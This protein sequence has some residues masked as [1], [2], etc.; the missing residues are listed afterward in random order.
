MFHLRGSFALLTLL[1]PS[2]HDVKG[3][4]FIKVLLLSL[5]FLRPFKGA[6]WIL[7]RIHQLQ[8][9][10]PNDEVVVIPLYIVVLL[11]PLIS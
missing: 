4:Y 2:Y 8:Q 6:E 1:D 10:E 5:L 11:Y 9:E 7:E 3:Y